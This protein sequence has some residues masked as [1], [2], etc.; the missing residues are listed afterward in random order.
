MTSID[1]CDVRRAT[2]H[3]RTWHVARRTC[4]SS[5]AVAL[6]AGGVVVSFAGPEHSGWPQWGGPTRDFVSR[7]TIASSW[8]EAGPRQMWRRPL[9]D[10]FAS[11]VSNGTLARTV[12]GL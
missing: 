8:P 2:S 7:A 9:G 12:L 6:I 5:V 4:L 11:I 3:S 10:G 1:T